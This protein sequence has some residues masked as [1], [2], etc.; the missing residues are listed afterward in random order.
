MESHILNHERQR[1]EPKDTVCLF[2]TNKSSTRNMEDNL[3]TPVYCVQDRTNLL[4]YSNVKFNKIEVGV[5]RCGNC[6]STHVKVNIVS[7]I[8]VF[9]AVFTTLILPVYLAV[10]FSLST[11]GMVI[12][13]ASTFGLTVL[14]TMGVEKGLLSLYDVKSKKDGSLRDPL[15][16]EFL[17]GGWSLKRPRA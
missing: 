13:L 7:N 17:R 14:I 15:I 9:I 2:C 6:R 12:A 4:V 1:F 11:V 8:F 16:K 3:F 10:K 5:P